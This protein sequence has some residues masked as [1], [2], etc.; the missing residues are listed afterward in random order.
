MEEIEDTIGVH[1][2][3]MKGVQ[4]RKTIQGGITY[5]VCPIFKNISTLSYTA[6]V[7][8]NDVSLATC[9]PNTAQSINELFLRLGNIPLMTSRKDLLPDNPMLLILMAMASVV[10]VVR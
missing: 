2:L 8:G 10:E 9:I 3:F 4:L 7:T 1:P 5:Q 6:N